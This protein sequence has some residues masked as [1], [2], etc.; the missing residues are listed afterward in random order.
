MD[1][2]EMR[3]K[4]YIQPNQFPYTIPSGNEY[5]SGDYEACLNKVLEMADYKKLRAE[6][7]EAREARAL[8]GHR[9]GQHDRAR[10]LR[11]EQLRHG[12][13]AHDRGPRGGDGQPST[14]WAT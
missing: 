1:P 9:P 2:A 3:R 8:P 5:D 10:A 7:A 11:L 13:A 12:R 4:N 6:Q 14:S